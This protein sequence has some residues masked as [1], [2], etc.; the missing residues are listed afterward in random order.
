MQKTTLVAATFLACAAPMQ[1]LAWEEPARGSALRSDLMDALRPHAEFV[2]GAPVVFVV[3]DLRVDGD[4]AFGMLT[5]VRPGGGEIGFDDLNSRI[6][7][8]E[9]RDFWGGPSM[10]AL[11][12][13]SGRTWVATH[14]VQ[15]AT[16]VWWA[17]PFFCPK[18]H[19]VIS[20]Y[21]GN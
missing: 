16:D 12:E 4:V 5:P 15:G 19:S 9:D 8:Y 14:Q 11:F 21:C 13:K 20:E 17:D 3:Q 1:A 18:W 10:Q 6:R 2:F 7:E